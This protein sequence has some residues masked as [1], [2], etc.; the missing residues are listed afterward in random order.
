MFWPLGHFIYFSKRFVAP[1]CIL[2]NIIHSKDDSLNT[3]PRAFYCAGEI[4]ISQS[5]CVPKA[6]Q[7][8]SMWRAKTLHVGP[9][10][11]VV[12]GYRCTV[13]CLGHFCAFETP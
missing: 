13:Q 2:S 1:L 5:S 8:T 7:L 4:L 3:C 11:A 6:S 9:L 10:S 12:E